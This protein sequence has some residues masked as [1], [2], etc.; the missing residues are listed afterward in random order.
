M[1]GDELRWVGRLRR[2][3][4]QFIHTVNGDRSKQQKSLKTILTTT[5]PQSN[6]RRARRSCQALPRISSYDHI[7]FTYY[8]FSKDAK[9]GL[10]KSI[11]FITLKVGSGEVKCKPASHAPISA[12]ASI[13]FGNCLLTSSQLSIY[14]TRQQ[15]SFSTGLRTISYFFVVRFPVSICHCIV[16]YHASWSSTGQIRGLVTANDKLGLIVRTLIKAE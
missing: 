14:S 4:L 13:T 6:L 7:A 3:W 11:S 5:S 1:P 10:L 2:F 9:I 16:N 12:F 8:M 15:I